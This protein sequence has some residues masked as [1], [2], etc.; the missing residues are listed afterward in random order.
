MLLWISNFFYVFNAVLF[1]SQLHKASDSIFDFSIEYFYYC[2]RM[3][4]SSFPLT[5]CLFLLFPSSIIRNIL[6]I[7]LLRVCHFYIQN[8][9]SYPH[10]LP[11]SLFTFFLLDLH[12]CLIVYTFIAAFSISPYL[13]LCCL[14][15]LIRLVLSISWLRAYPISFYVS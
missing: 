15:N 8:V 9:Q 1:S 6:Y 4:H 13:L 2:T 10:S 3:F 14:G 11:F 5:L 7:S 12:Y